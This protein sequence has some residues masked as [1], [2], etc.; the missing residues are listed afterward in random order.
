[1]PC[2]H[3]SSRVEWHRHRVALCGGF[4]SRILA[5][6]E[7]RKPGGAGGT[8]AVGAG[9]D[10]TGE[11]VMVDVVKVPGG[12]AGGKNGA[13]VPGSPVAVKTT[14]T[15]TVSGIATPLISTG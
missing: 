1:M 8:A 11:R 2:N 13:T 14:G 9:G 5:S 7:S 12:P 10:N 4:E 6:C 3:R 15:T